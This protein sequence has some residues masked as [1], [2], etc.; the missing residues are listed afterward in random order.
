MASTASVCGNVG[1]CVVTYVER[2]CVVEGS[3][4]KSH[5][6]VCGVAGGKSF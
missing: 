5:R 2:T 3:K 6:L 1:G 4:K